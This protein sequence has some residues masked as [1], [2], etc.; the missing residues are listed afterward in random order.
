MESKVYVRDGRV[1][2]EADSIT[3]AR[4]AMTEYWRATARRDHRAF[5]MASCIA[6]A[7]ALLAIVGWIRFWL[8]SGGC[9]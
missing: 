4:E 5:L 1:I 6:G 2:I 3:E 8:V 7:T 9:R